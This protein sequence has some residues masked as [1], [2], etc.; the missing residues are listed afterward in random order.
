MLRSRFSVQL[1]AGAVAP[2]YSG[3]M[4]NGGSGVRPANA[5]LRAMMIR[6]RSCFLSGVAFL[7][8][9][10]QLAHAAECAALRERKLQGGSVT[11]A[12]M[13]STG[14]LTTPYGEKLEKLPALCRVAGVLRPSTDSVIHFEVW[15]PASG[16]NG[17]LLGVGNGGYAGT[18]N[19]GQ[20][21]ES[22][23]QGYATASTD[24][25]HEAS[26]E[27]ASW[28]YHHPE[29]VIDYGYRSI[30]LTAVQAKEIVAAFYGHR[31][32]HTYFDA[33]SNGGRE[34]LMEAQRFPE[35]Y[36]GILAGAPANNWTRMLS[37]DIDISQAMLAN[38]AAYISNMKLPAIQRSALQACDAADG[39]KDGIVNNPEQCH[40]DP[41]TLLCHGEETR[42]CLTAPQI[43]TLRKLYTGGA[44]KEGEILFPGYTPGSEQPGWEYW[45]T[46]PGPGAAAGARYPVQYF[47]YMVFQDPKWDLMTADAGASMRA[48]AE[49]LDGSL[50]AVD[51]DLS[52]FAGRG[53]KLIL[54]HGCNDAAISP[55]I[56]IQYVHSVSEKMGAARAGE[57]LRLYMMAGTEHCAGG[58]G[59]SNFGQLG[60][61][62]ADA[63]SGA[64]EALEQWVEH[65]KAP[66]MLIGA[67]MA[68]TGASAKVVMTRPVCPYPEVVTYKGSGSTD[69]AENFT[70]S[71]P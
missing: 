1:S 14:T 34:A 29:K 22:V 51:P 15:M 58:P 50:V 19:F 45:V 30:H 9:L 63:G 31:A 44:T 65:G 28:A 6:K 35:D 41:A 59:A 27:D 33:C 17:R 24:T 13:V 3:E 43:A 70:C 37:A 21:A 61:H 4:A 57:M 16:W 62:S 67:K 32:D 52:R 25:G 26:A 53:G 69:L 60:M 12:E 23:R 64:I 7:L 10:P 11:L 55:Y 39:V 68:G 47:R 36:D 48:A 49:K 20:M 38:P 18:I 2:A 42:A 54:Y 66:E 46:G 8:L 5:K 40:F 71:K 56:T